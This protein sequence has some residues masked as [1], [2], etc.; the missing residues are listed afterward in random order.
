MYSHVSRSYI[1]RIRIIP[2]FEGVDTDKEVSNLECSGRIRYGSQCF[3]VHRSSP[4]F[5]LERT[6]SPMK[7]T[8]EQIRGTALMTKKLARSPLTGEKKTRRERLHRHSALVSHGESSRARE[9]SLGARIE[10]EAD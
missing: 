10:N 2:R 9:R 4:P 6:R 7:M 1:L 5:S 3:P 8:A